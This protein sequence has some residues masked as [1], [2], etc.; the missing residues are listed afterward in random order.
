MG[1][2]QARFCERFGVKLPLSTRPGV[3][4][5]N[6]PNCRDLSAAFCFTTGPGKGCLSIFYSFIRYWRIINRLDACFD[7]AMYL[8]TIDRHFGI[9]IQIRIHALQAG[10]KSHCIGSKRCLIHKPMNNSKALFSGR[11]T[12]FLCRTQVD[13]I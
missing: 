4:V 8:N 3:L 13:R 12:G 5:F 9:P 11:T 2:Y 10:P 7:R 6:N 1:D